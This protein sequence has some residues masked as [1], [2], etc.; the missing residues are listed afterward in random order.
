MGAITKLSSLLGRYRLGY[1]HGHQLK[2]LP[3][4]F[5]YAFSLRRWRLSKLFDMSDK[6]FSL[7]MIAFDSLSPWERALGAPIVSY[8]LFPQPFSQ[9]EKGE[10]TKINLPVDA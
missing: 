4:P 8:A 3:R 9:R 7:L 6:I 2:L 5:S 1:A 10:K